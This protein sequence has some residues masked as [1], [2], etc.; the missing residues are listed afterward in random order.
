MLHQLFGIPIWDG[1]FDTSKIDLQCTMTKKWESQTETSFGSN[2]KLTQPSLDYLLKQL[3]LFTNEIMQNKKCQIR[4]VG[5]WMT[6]YAHKD[7]QESHIHN[8][9]HFSFT[10]FKNIPKNC[11]QFKFYHPLSDWVQMYENLKIP[12]LIPTFWG[13]Q[14]PDTIIIFPSFLRHMVTAGTTKKIRV[15]YSGNFNIQL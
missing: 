4:L 5:F 6:K 9:T 12:S 13:N 14:R 3:S 15:T 10:I 11:G 1:P 7:F 2:N 8:W